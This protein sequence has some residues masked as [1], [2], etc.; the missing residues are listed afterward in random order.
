MASL[1]R[2]VQELGK[3]ILLFLKEVFE[4]QT[5]KA[6]GLEDGDMGG[7]VGRSSDEA[8]NERGAKG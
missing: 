2:G 7:G 5:L 3:P 6:Q 4:V 1:Q 8:C